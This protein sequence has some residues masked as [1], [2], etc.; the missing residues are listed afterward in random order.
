MRLADVHR[1]VG[2][3]PENGAQERN[4]VGAK[5]IANVLCECVMYTGL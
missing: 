2:M 5:G 3:H 4:V 1:S